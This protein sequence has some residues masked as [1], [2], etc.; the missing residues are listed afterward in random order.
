[1]ESAP[2]A[3]VQTPPTGPSPSAADALIASSSGTDA[4][5]ARPVSARTGQPVSAPPV[6]HRRPWHRPHWPL[7]LSGVLGVAGLLVLAASAVLLVRWFLTLDFMVDFLSRFPGE[8]HLPEGTA[9]GLPA[10]ARWGHFFNMFLIVLII[11]SGLQVRHQRKPPAYWASKGNSGQKISINL[12]FH[13]VL[14]VLWL[15]NGIIFVVLLLISGHWARIVPTGWEVFPNA[16]SAILQYASLDWPTE[17]GWVNYNALQQLAYF[18]TVFLAAPLAV[19]S[20]FRMSTLWPKNVPALD[21]AYPVE[22]ARAIHL[23]VMLYFVVFIVFHVALVLSTGALRNLNHMYSGQD[24]VNWAGFWI[25]MGSVALVAVAWTATRP[26]LI[27]P[28][29]RLFGTVS[30]R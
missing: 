8:Y 17:N 10:W 29:A 22:V 19:I 28:I 5:L 15:A 6:S 14:D 3:V 4:P 12:W 20:G 27:A 1:M 11:R 21:R 23:P 9:P 7:V 2:V 25:F 24:V 26:L 13:L 16:L 18:V 30:S